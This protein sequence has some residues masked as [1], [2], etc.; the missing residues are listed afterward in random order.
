[1]AIAGFGNVGRTV[2][3]LLADDDEYRI[4]G[5]S[6]IS[7]A[8]YDARGLEVNEIARTVDSGGA[9]IDAHDGE[10][11]AIGELLNADC[12]IL[13]PAAVGGV[14]DDANAERL[15]ARIIVE[16]ANAPTSPAADEIL[17]DRGTLIVPDILANAGGVIGSYFEW[18]HG[19]QA[20]PWLGRHISDRLVGWMHETYARVAAHSNSEQLTMRDAALA[21]AVR[22]V[23][24]THAVRGLYP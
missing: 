13:V 24:D 9:V 16:G 20:M 10:M 14:I 12:D 11:M 21:I 1:M 7:G 17:T 22:R 3:E 15:P 23:A 6:D 5:I 4:V 18:V 8:R 2:A 19:R